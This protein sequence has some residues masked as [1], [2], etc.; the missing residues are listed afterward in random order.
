MAR[1]ASLRTVIRLRVFFTGQIMFVVRS[2]RKAAEGRADMP[3]GLTLRLDRAHEKATLA[4]QL[5]RIWVTL[6]ELPKSMGIAELDI[7]LDGTLGAVQEI[8]RRAIKRLRDP[9]MKK[10]AARLLQALFPQGAAEVIRLPIELE[11][12]EARDVLAVLVDPQWADVVSRLG[13]GVYA[14]QLAELIEQIDAILLT[15]G[16]GRPSW[17]GVEAAR[18][19]AQEALL[20][21]TA[22]IA[23][24]WSE[25]EDI[26]T[27]EALLA[28]IYAQ[29][30][31]IAESLKTG[32]RVVD[33]DPESG[34]PEVEPAV[35]DTGTTTP[36]A[37]AGPG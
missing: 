14:E 26:A 32:R 9:E 33:V 29:D 31:R 16:G 37:P 21:L 5:E 4:R 20:R 8:L 24:T 7:E 15:R 12:E 30:E 34:E 3:P 36:A 28:P 2:I 35:A 17:D 27:R 13:L 22:Y 6:K 11:L 19:E 25:E 1:K 18:A 10:R 23:G